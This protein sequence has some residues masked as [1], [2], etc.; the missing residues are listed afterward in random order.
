M[1]AGAMN[2]LWDYDYLDVPH[3]PRLGVV[4][5]TMDLKL[6]KQKSCLEQ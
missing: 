6:F 3:S 5:I 2:W 4:T 1:V